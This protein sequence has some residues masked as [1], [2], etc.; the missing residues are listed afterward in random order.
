MRTLLKEIGDLYTNFT[1]P[2]YEAG[3]L[4]KKTKELIAFSNSVIIDCKP[5]MK[6]HLNQALSAGASEEEINEAVAL[7]MT[8]SAGKARLAAQE[9]INNL[10]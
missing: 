3:H 6:V 5:C 1:G 10:G 8:V 9:T 7:A 4:D 2:V